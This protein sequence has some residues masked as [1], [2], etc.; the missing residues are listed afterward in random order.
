MAMVRQQPESRRLRMESRTL[1]LSGNKGRKARKWP[2]LCLRSLQHMLG[3]GF[4][5]DLACTG[6]R[7][8]GVSVHLCTN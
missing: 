5:Y 8:L 3:E 7:Y 4:R 1:Q 2:Q 6:E